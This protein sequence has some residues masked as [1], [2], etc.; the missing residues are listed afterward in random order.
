[1]MRAKVR[2]DMYGLRHVNESNGTGT[3]GTNR[4]ISAMKIDREQQ[5]HTLR[6]LADTY[7]D[8]VRGAD[9]RKLMSVSFDE[10][11]T[12][13]FRA[14]LS[15]L[16][17]HQLIALHRPPYLEDVFVDASITAK[18]LDFLADDGDLSAILGVVTIKLHDDTLKSLIEAKILGS[19]LPQ[20]DKKRWIDQLRSLPAETT[21]HLALKL[22]DLGLAN[23]PTALAVIGS[24]IGLGAA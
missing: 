1:M 8:I 12:K 17:E 16:A 3:H 7:P 10:A 22:V 19:D 18:G 14:N 11:D 5:R 21:K 13:N 2:S 4:R 20:P 23:A 6:V 9:L 24:A 15:Y